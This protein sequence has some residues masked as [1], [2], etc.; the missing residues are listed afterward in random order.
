M[1]TPLKQECAIEVVV[2]HKCGPTASV[3][4]GCLVLVHVVDCS[5]VGKW[6]VKGVDEIGEVCWLYV[7]ERSGLCES[8]WIGCEL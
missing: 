8:T 6:Y 7:G 2:G 3:C 1:G 5:G 4:S